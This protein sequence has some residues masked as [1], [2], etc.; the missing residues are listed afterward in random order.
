M[1]LALALSVILASAPLVA[2]HSFATMYL[3]DDLIE[4]E[5]EIVQFQYQNPHSWV[6]VD[7]FDPF[8]KRKTYAAEWASRAR[9]EDDGIQ[10]DTLRPATASGSGR[11]P[12]ATRATTGFACGASSAV[13]AGGGGRSNARSA[14]DPVLPGPGA[15]CSIVSKPSPRR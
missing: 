13:T 9:L 7:G 15:A 10:K 3:E 5:G 8:G 12:T 2:H 1:R 6:H 14:D 4:V 11:R